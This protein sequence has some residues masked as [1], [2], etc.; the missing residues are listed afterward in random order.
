M[1]DDDEIMRFSDTLFGG[2]QLQVLRSKHF[3]GFTFS[4][5]VIVKYLIFFFASMEH[6]NLSLEMP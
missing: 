1:R 4:R 5:V 6:P 3:V 2:V